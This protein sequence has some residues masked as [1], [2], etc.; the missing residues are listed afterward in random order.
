VDRRPLAQSG[1]VGLQKDVMVRRR[2]VD[3]PGFDYG[4][5]LSKRC[6]KPGTAQKIRQRARVAAD[7][8]TTKTDAVQGTGS[9]AMKRRRG[10]RP[11]AEAPITTIGSMA[12]ST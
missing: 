5:V 12:T 7:V 11:P 6:G 9:A 1:A 2:H 4:A 3:V 10:S 8:M